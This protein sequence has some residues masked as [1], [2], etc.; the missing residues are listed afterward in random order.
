MDLVTSDAAYLN[1]VSSI[2]AGRLNCV[3]SKGWWEASSEKFYHPLTD[4]HN[5]SAETEWK[6]ILTLFSS[7]MR[8]NVIVV[9]ENDISS[10]NLNHETVYF[11]SFDM[12]RS[13]NC[14]TFSWVQTF[15]SQRQKIIVNVSLKLESPCSQILF[16]IDCFWIILGSNTII[17]LTIFFFYK[18]QFLCIHKYYV[19]AQNWLL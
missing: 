8:L 17:E 9:N 1:G 2:F 19:M 7:K 4:M 5:S 16:Q 15:L 18:I 10:Q 13:E 6:H 11:R 3:T 12:N 14:L